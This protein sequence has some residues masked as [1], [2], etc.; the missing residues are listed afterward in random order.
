MKKAIV[1]FEMKSATCQNAKFHVKR[2][3]INLRLKMLYFDTF[4]LEF[5][6]TVLIFEI[7][8]FMLLDVKRKKSG[9]ENA[10]FVYFLT[11]I[12]KTRVEI[13]GLGFV[14]HESISWSREQKVRKTSIFHELFFP[15]YDK[16]K[17]ISAG[18]ICRFIYLELNE[19]D[20]SMKET[21]LVECFGLF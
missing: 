11:G 16:F 5:E 13:K 10:L 9:N 14:N 20:W 6:K 19:W 2:K 8:F 1:I 3:K 7:S 12:W 21:I 4:R 15:K 18:Q 17:I